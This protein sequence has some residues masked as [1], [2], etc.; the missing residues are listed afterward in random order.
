[1]ETEKLLKISDIEAIV[2]KEPKVRDS[3]KLI[4]DNMRVSLD[5][6]DGSKIRDFWSLRKLCLP[7]FQKIVTVADKADLWSLYLEL[8]KEAHHLKALQ[9]KESGFVVDQIELAISNLEQSISNFFDSSSIDRSYEEDE[10]FISIQSLNHRSEWYQNKHYEL[11]W[12][13]SF[14]SKII[15]LRKELIGLGMRFKVKS[16]F[17]QKLSVM[18]NKVFPLRKEIVDE[19]SQA[20]TLDVQA[21]IEKYF[22][23]SDRKSL[24][25]SVFFLRKEIKNLQSAAKKLL[26]TSE[27]FS[28]TRQDLSKQWD[29]LKGLEKEIRKE[30]GEIR[31]V[32]QKHREEIEQLIDGIQSSYQNNESLRKVRKDLDT[33]FKTI[34]A[35]TLTHEDVVFL[36]E[37]AQVL[38][39]EVDVKLTEEED[40]YKAQIEKV[41]A[42]R[43]AMVRGLLSRIN[44]ISLD[45]EPST[46]DIQAIESEL[47]SI[48]LEFCALSGL[49]KSENLQIE[50]GLASIEKR[51]IVIQ[52]DVLLSSESRDKICVMSQVLDQRLERRKS[53]KQKLESDKKLLGSSGLDFEQALQLSA[54]VEDDKSSLE[55]LDADIL[56]LKQEI[57]QMKRNG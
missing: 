32:S 47:S 16:L 19:V 17:F 23:K 14:A 51:L 44:A 29:L 31:E 1:M 57:A 46:I 50:K 20:F 49:E 52:E 56:R 4:L 15:D 11:V 9:E 39:S 24:K 7:L 36:K 30:Q 8:T 34:R 12:L 41:N 35:K 25:R 38:A 3:I 10:F 45:G 43:K 2:K 26:V 53:L 22:N 21:F 33:V 40:L 6:K 13:S 5:S 27:V 54:L 55:D 42:E 28:S 18:G 48:K 37:K